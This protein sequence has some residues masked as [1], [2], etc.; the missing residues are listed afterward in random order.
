MTSPETNKPKPVDKQPPKR[1]PK[2]KAKSAPDAKGAP[3]KGTITKRTITKGSAESSNEIV[4]NEIVY[5]ELNLEKWSIWEPASSKKKPPKARTF[6][7]ELQLADGSTATAK[8]EIG[9]TSRGTLNTRD[10]KIYYVLLKLWEEGGKPE[11]PVVFSLQKIAR[12]LGEEWS[13]HTHRSIVHSLLQ[14]RG[15]LFVWENSYFEKGS[16]DFVERLDTFNILSDLRIARRTRG[17][18]V[19]TESCLFFFHP[20]LLESLKANHTTPLFLDT[21]LSFKSEIAQLLY[22]RL[23]LLLADKTQYERR[24][25]ELFEDLGLEGSTYKHPSARKRVIERALIEL[26]GVPITTGSI[27]SAQVEKTKDGT[28][29]KIVIRKGPARKAL[30]KAAPPTTLP[31]APDAPKNPAPADQTETD[32]KTEIQKRAQSGGQRE[33]QPATGN[34][35]EQNNP[36][37]NQSTA[38][39]RYFHQ[40]FHA[41]PMES[42]TPLRA[43]SKESGQAQRL[44]EE[45]GWDK[46]RHLVDFAKAEAAKT[47]YQPAS[48]NGILQYE[49]RA[50]EDWEASARAQQTRQERIATQKARQTDEEARQRTLILALCQMAAQMQEEHP[51]AFTAFEESI[52]I[53]KAT[54]ASS[55]IFPKSPVLQEKVLAEFD[56]EHK[57]LEL[58]VEYFRGQPSPL[59][60]LKAWL[61]EHSDAELR[62]ILARTHK[63]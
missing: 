28:D 2:S 19:T 59:A 26:E 20:Q 9:F 39:L 55:P 41:A 3:T 34:N 44:I 30:P 61:R 54:L 47:K 1:T 58:F 18:H 31:K 23:D 51:A 16:G 12:L 24:T 25:K 63:G 49:G 36:P 53:R 33:G 22:A 15:V 62:E 11:I 43:S 13:R 29:F 10:Q 57:R 32:Q 38:L 50:L 14:L 7:R 40:Q 56:T 6:E 4:I 17:Q 21:V 52:E 27:I 37:E 60:E 5:A 48:L 35:A 45:H 46:A 8:V 42:K